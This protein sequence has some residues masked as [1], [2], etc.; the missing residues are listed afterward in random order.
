MPKAVRGFETEPI[1]KIVFS[2]GIIPESRDI[3]PQPFS[4]TIFP[5]LTTPRTS[6]GILFFC[7][8]SLTMAS[9]FWVN[10]R[11]PLPEA[12]IEVEQDKGRLFDWPQEFAP[13]N[14]HRTV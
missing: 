8:K 9:A 7:M 2:L 10:N 14:K 3:T 5:F 4:T 12:L 6:P 11:S 1:L 13:P